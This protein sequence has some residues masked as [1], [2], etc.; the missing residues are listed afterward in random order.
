MQVIILFFIALPIAAAWLPADK[1]FKWL[2]KHHRSATT[3]ILSVIVILLLTLGL[4]AV[5]LTIGN[6]ISNS[7]IRSLGSEGGGLPSQ[8]NMMWFP[9]DLLALGIWAGFLSGYVRMKAIDK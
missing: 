7:S 5:G 6:H 3:A 2:R 8:A 9:F 1:F 4:T